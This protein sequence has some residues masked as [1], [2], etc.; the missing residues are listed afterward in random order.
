[1]RILSWNCQGLGNSWTVRSFHKLVKDQAPTTCFLMETR[2]DREGF[3]YHCRELPYP[4]KF[5]VKKPNGGGG[6]ALIWKAEVQLD[7]INFTEHHIIARVVEDDGF[8]WMLTCFYEWLEASQKHKSWALFNHLRSF[9]D[10]PW[11]CIGDFNAIISSIE[12]QSRFPPPF[13]QMDEFRAAL[14]ACNL[15]DLGYVGYPYT[16]NNKRPEMDNTKDRLDRVVANTGWRN[17]F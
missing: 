6:L 16:W 9:V 15:V 7:V 3:E 14:D 11:C 13:K 4:N 5:L 17:K 8:A 10:C 2:L 1:M 12:K